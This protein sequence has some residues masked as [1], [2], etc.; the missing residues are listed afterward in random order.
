MQSAS[1]LGWISHTCRRRL[2]KSSKYFKRSFSSTTC[3]KIEKPLGST[4]AD[5]SRTRNIGIIAHIDAVSYQRSTIGMFEG[6]E[7]CHRARLRRR[8]VCSIIVAILGELE[9]NLGSIVQ[10]SPILMLY[11]I[12]HG[13]HGFLYQ[14]LFILVVTVSFLDEPSCTS[15][16]R[17]FDLTYIYRRRRWLYGH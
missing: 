17:A 9:V 13:L 1:L 6:T 7:G 10:H 12:F 11:F 2:Q 3:R 14:G 16:V 15:L 8:S 5:L 4:G